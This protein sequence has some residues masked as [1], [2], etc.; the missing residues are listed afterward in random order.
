[1]SDLC[2][3]TTASPLGVW[4]LLWKPAVRRQVFLLRLWLFSEENQLYVFGHLLYIPGM[5]LSDINQNFS[6]GTPKNYYY[7]IIMCICVPYCKSLQNTIVV[8]RIQSADN[9]FQK[10]GIS[11]ETP[12]SIGQCPGLGVWGSG[13]ASCNGEHLHCIAQKS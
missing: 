11:M 7:I 4:V 2:I 1:M 13:T 9:D 3:G 10:V 6:W 12:F 8:P 5:Y